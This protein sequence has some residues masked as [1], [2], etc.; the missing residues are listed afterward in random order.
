VEERGMGDKFIIL[1]AL[2]I[3]EGAK[4]QI[5]CNTFFM[6]LTGKNTLKILL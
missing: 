3:S 1:F 2:K 4:K 6:F 5:A